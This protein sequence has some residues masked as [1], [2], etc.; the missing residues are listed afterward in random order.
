MEMFGST[1]APKGP[2]TSNADLGASAL[3]LLVLKLGIS[4]KRRETSE[5]IEIGDLPTREQDLGDVE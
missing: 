4:M 3:R 2:E 5:G 1:S